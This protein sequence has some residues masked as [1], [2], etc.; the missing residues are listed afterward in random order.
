MSNRDARSVANLAT[1]S[2]DLATFFLSQK[3]TVTNL[4]ASWTNFSEFLIV[5]TAAMA[6]KY[7]MNT[8]RQLDK[9]EQDFCFCKYLKK[10]KKTCLVKLFA[11]IGALYFF[12]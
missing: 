7:S 6:L 4:A 5:G 2:L 11:G 12:L 3:A 8:E 9:T 10:K 1:L